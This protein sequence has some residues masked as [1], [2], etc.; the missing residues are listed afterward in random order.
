MNTNKAKIEKV[1]KVI[2]DAWNVSIPVPAGPYTVL[3]WFA[4]GGIAFWIFW[5]IGK[6][7]CLFT[8]KEMRL[9]FESK[10]K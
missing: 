3:C 4:G 6:F 5:I 7:Y 9:V 2:S 1:K 8:H 10:T